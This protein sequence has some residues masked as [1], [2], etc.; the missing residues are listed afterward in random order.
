VPGGQCLDQISFTSTAGAPKACLWVQALFLHHGEDPNGPPH[1]GPWTSI[2]LTGFD[3]EWPA[4]QIREEQACLKRLWDILRRYVEVG[5]IAPLDPV[6]YLS[7]LPEQDLILLQTAVQT[8]EKINTDGETALRSRGP[9]GGGG[10]RR[11][12]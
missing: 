12:R 9:R 6:A 5:D 8:L 2:C 11:L 3:I 10:A 1:D 7:A 4:F